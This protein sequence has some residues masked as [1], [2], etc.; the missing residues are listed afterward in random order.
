MRVTCVR[1]R[2]T[3]VSESVLS[4]FAISDQVEWSVEIGET[5]LVS[6]ICTYH[7]GNVAYY[8]EPGLGWKPAQLFTVADPF[9]DGQWACSFLQ[10]ES[11]TD[12]PDVRIMVAYPEMIMDSS[13]YADLLKGRGSAQAAHDARVRG[14]ERAE[15]ERHVIAG[16]KQ[17]S[18]SALACGKPKCSAPYFIRWGSECSDE[19]YDSVVALE[20]DA[21]GEAGRR[22]LALAYVDGV[23]QGGIDDIVHAVEREIGLIC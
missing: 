18:E 6:S 7:D 5:Y 1:N 11:L 15:F 10:P 8:I 9:L 14:M 4:R 23:A 21:Q 17:L 20:V 3:D 13:H 19:D 2:G 16:V 22:V 12:A